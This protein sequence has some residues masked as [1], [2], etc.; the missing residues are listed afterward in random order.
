MSKYPYWSNFTF[1]LTSLT[2]GSLLVKFWVLITCC[3]VSLVIGLPSLPIDMVS[4]LIE[5]FDGWIY[6]EGCKSPFSSIYSAFTF[7]SL[8]RL[9]I[10]PL[11]ISG[12]S[13][14]KLLLSLTI[15][16]LFTGI[17]FLIA[18]S[19]SSTPSSCFSSSCSSSTFSSFLSFCSFFS[20]SCFNSSC[21]SNNSSSFN[22]SG[23]S[24]SASSNFNSLKNSLYSSLKFSIYSDV[25]W[26]LPFSSTVA[27]NSP[28][29]LYISK[30]SAFSFPLVLCNL[31]INISLSINLAESNVNSL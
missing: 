26:I 27:I 14:Y 17:P 18:I 5:V 15:N 9:K 3:G 13:L 21:S 23:S 28:S 20:T 10:K 2:S 25:N 19:C 1:I 12:W 8:S 24:N 7:P 16:T 11:S 29:L 31:V 4:C 30:T 22:P 6:L